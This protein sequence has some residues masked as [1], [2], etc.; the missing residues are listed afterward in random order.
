M[1]LLI[2]YK[3]QYNFNAANLIPVNMYGPHDN[4]NPA[5][6]HVIPALILKI[7]RA[8]HVGK[9]EI[10]LWGTGEA[11]REFLYVDDCADAITQSLGIDTSPEPINIGTGQEIKI[12]DLIE[13]LKTIMGYS[14]DIVFNSDFPDGQPR[15]CLDT[16]R[17]SNALGFQ[18]ETHLY[19][20]LRQTVSWYYSNKER[21]KFNDYFDHIQ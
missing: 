12:K 7:D 20:G 16:S 15:R 18:A 21:C 14:G 5:I 8:M 2:A 13:M 1:E 4:F 6:S 9:K 3:K 17:A 11:S 19:D 10:E